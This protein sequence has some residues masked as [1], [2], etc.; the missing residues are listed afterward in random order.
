M[1]PLFF[2]RS[3]ARTFDQLVKPHLRGLYRF[4]H[5]LTGNPADAEDLVQDVMLKLYPRTR[6]LEAV[7]DLRPWL[8]RVLY[9]QFVDRD[10]KGKRRQEQSVTDTGDIENHQAFLDRYPGEGLGP[11]ADMERGRAGRMV[12]EALAELPPDQRALL[13]MYDVEGWEQQAIAEVLEVAPGTIK[14]RLHRCRQK[15]REQLAR[16]MEP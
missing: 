7:Q 9:R 11:L 2:S 10:R 1:Y 15:L 5:R 14:S 4:A 6:E 13:I 8:N 12:Q 3:Q 16:R